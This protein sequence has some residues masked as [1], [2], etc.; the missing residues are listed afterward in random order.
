VWDINGKK[1]VRRV[2]VGLNVLSLGFSS[3]GQTL[4]V[5]C[6][7]LISLWKVDTGQRVI[8]DQGHDGA[9]LALAFSPNGKVIA[10]AALDT[11]VWNLSTAEMLYR[12][13]GGPREIRAVGFSV[14]GRYVASESGRIERTLCV[15][16]A[17]T[18]N[19]VE[20]HEMSSKP[21]GTIAFCLD[22]T[23]RVALF[24]TSTMP[25]E[26]WEPSTRRTLLTLGRMEK[27]DYVSAVAFSARGQAVAVSWGFT[28][29]DRRPDSRN[30]IGIWN[31]D[32]TQRRAVLHVD[33]EVGSLAFSNNGTLLAVG[34]MHGRLDIWDVVREKRVLQVAGDDT[35][36][37]SIAFS[38]DDRTLLLGGHDGRVSWRETATGTLIRRFE[39]HRGIIHAITVS[40][41]GKHCASGSDDT[42]ALVWDL[43]PKGFDTYVGQRPL[44]KDELERLWTDIGV[45]NS[46]TAYRAIWALSARADET[47]RFFEKRLTPSRDTVTAEE[48]AKLIGDLGSNQRSV[49]DGASNTLAKLGEEA[50]PLLERT[51][52]RKPAAEVQ[53]RIEQL[54]EKTG[55]EGLL[56][57]QL[58]QIRAVHVCETIANQQG[59]SLLE[60]LAGGADWALQT[61]EAKVALQRL[62]ESNRKIPPRQR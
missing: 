57:F 24:D 58:Q 55:T 37:S 11:R 26:I 59:R 7:K 5:G 44:G 10:T 22:K 32:K 46:E 36:I 51:L 18:G 50:V 25:V 33:R 4:A 15:R 30:I 20:E 14:D 21:A 2:D 54:L 42:T 3:D 16:D 56:P 23:L 38:P 17:D 8:G 28:L 53:M 39:G 47:I 41:S 49:R 1:E 48:I 13:K 12:F 62:Q 35:V 61:R 27:G 43:A 52:R 6:D 9:V 60:S 29:G 45:R 31:V 40:Q 19:T 34:D